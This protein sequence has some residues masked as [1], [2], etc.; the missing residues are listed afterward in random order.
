MEEQREKKCALC[1]AVFD[2]VAETDSG[3]FTC[4]R[5]ATSERYDGVNL[6]AINITNYYARLAELEARNKELETEIA[7]L[8]KRHG[9]IQDR[10]GRYLDV[11]R[12]VPHD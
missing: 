5:C 2:G 3:E 11:A 6:V 1:G 4:R 8:R 12:K 7:H 10:H 9:V